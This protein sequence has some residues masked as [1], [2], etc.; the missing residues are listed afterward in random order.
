MA[1]LYPF[2]PQRQT[3]IIK[4]HL[5]P[6]GAIFSKA[7]EIEVDF[8]NAEMVMCFLRLCMNKNENVKALEKHK[9]LHHW[10]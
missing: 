7:E 10:C 6:T 1:N 4:C 9:D 2:D 5:D 3:L 8:G